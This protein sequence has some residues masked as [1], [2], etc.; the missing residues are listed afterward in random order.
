VE[1]VVSGN[2]VF[3]SRG[4]M[5]VLLALNNWAVPFKDD[6]T[7]LAI[8]S[9]RRN[10][11]KSDS[12]FVTAR[13]EAARRKLCGDVSA[14]NAW[15]E[16]MLALKAKVGDNDA[17]KAVWQLLAEADLRDEFFADRLNA[18]V[19][20]FPATFDASG[21]RF[22]RDVWFNHA[23]FLGPVNFSAAKF[24]ADVNFEGTTFAAVANF[25]EIRC[26]G[27][28]EMRAT[29]FQAT[30]AFEGAEFAKDA[31]FRDSKFV[32]QAMFRGAHF[33]GEA[34]LGACKFSG[35]ADFSDVTFIDNAGFDKTCFEQEVTFDE[36]RFQRHAWFA[37]AEF[38]KEASFEKARF[39]GKMHFADVSVA[40]SQSPAGRHLRDLMKRSV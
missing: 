2:G 34:G 32:G 30:V 4:P 29:A 13:R 19:R 21:A 28:A 25:S 23:H 22:E 8:I 33:R 15:A 10:L 9:R 7:R 11:R 37:S 12:A 16:N 39:L 20:V 3:F 27:R 5:E 18:G 35:N 6:L 1:F 40:P 31:W 36:S 26:R 17:L 14:W 24:G 38:R